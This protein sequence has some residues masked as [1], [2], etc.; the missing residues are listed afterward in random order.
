MPETIHLG[1]VS[2]EPGRRALI[3]LPVAR[4]TTGSPVSLP[5]TVLNGARPGP[6]LWLDAAIH[7]DELNGLEIIRRVLARLDPRHL[8]GAVLA[9]PVVNVFG[10]IHQDRYLPD[11]RDL[12]RSFPGS[13]RGSLAAR[14]AHLF[15]TEI[16][17]RCQ[18]GIDLHT[19]SLH[20]TNLPQIRADLTDA[21]T[22]RLA[23][24]FGAPL[25]FSAKPIGGSLRAAAVRRKLPLLVYEAGEPLRFNRD[26][27]DT[28][29]GGVLRAL[30]ALGMWELA[31]AQPPPITLHAEGARWLRAPRS[32]IFHLE[33]TLGQRV[34]R[35][36]QLGHISDPFSTRSHPVRAP[37]DGLVIGYT[38][39]PLVYQGG[40][41]L[42]LA[43]EVSPV[44]PR[45]PDGEPAARN[46]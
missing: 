45:P 1:E 14:L 22:R 30:A 10:F 28:G 25:M 16:V 7:G 35:R 36:Q 27:I 29:V 46:G 31:E 33:A 11:R 20:R 40:A 17:S 19:G 6:R 39:N 9:V 43:R 2:V 32:G 26:A 13:P 34:E 37:E 18:V 41:L 12:N 44:V 38:N 42:H 15:M 5:V 21:E 8:G 4:L 23:E 24:A 3:Q